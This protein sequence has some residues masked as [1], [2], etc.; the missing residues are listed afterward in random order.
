MH[1]S[2]EKNKPLHEFTTFKIGGPARFFIAISSI[3]KLA[4]TIRYCYNHQMAYLVIG[5]GSNILFDDRGFNGLVILNQIQSIEFRGNEIFAGAGY[6]F[7]LL[8]TQT[9]RAGLSGLEF[10][11]G[12]PGSVGGAVYMNAGANGAQTADVVTKISY[13]SE[14]GE[15]LHFQKKDLQFGYRFSSFQTLKGAI[16]SAQFSLTPISDA[17]EKQ[18]QII[19]YRTATQPLKEKSAGCVFRNPPQTSAGALIEKCGLKGMQIGSA[20]VSELHAN[21]IVNRGGA[22]A[23]DVLQ[24]IDCIKKQVKDKTDIDL[25]LEI[26]FI[27]F[28]K[29]F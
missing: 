28:E 21:F 12:I 23:K 4:E 3:E 6:S 29:Q 27:P 11:S 17:R 16:A 10:A 19:R 2:F 13:I 7:S 5:K 1:A 25:E 26:R 24:L 15:L 14:K 18:I 22:K 20:L 8:G 9:A